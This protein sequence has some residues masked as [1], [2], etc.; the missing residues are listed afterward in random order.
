M[1]NSKTIPLVSLLLSALLIPACGS[2]DLLSGDDNKVVAKI[3]DYK[4]TVA[5]FKYEIKDKMPAN[6]SPADLERAKE[7]LLDAVITKKLLIQEAQK[8]NFDKERAFIK[9]IERYWEQALLKLLYNKRSRELLREISK[10]E[11]DPKIRDR[12]VREAL[13]A[14]IENLKKRADIKR[15]KENLKAVRP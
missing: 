2:N 10:D 1:F 14:W 12:R 9:E 15:Y 3:N 7:D 13:D 5:D 6:L 8:Q 11:S 4:L